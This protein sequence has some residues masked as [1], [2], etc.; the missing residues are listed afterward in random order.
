MYFNV[1]KFLIFN[2]YNLLI[3]VKVFYRLPSK[4]EL[5]IQAWD[6]DSTSLRKDEIMDKITVLVREI[7]IKCDQFDQYT[8]LQGR[9]KLVTSL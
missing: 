1:Y 2:E 9:T 8:V 4:I 7:E 5:K 6:V 3:T